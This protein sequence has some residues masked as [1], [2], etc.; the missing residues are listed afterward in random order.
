[1][2]STVFA[3]CLA[4]TTV[5]AQGTSPLP[6]QTQDLL[7]D[8][9]IRVTV[10][11][12]QVD[13]TVTDSKGRHVT[14]LKPRD[15][16]ILQDG[17]PQVI[18][19]FSSVTAP[20]SV[21]APVLS[22]LQQK[23]TPLLA[24]VKPQFGD[25][26]RT[27]ALVVDDL[28]LSFESTASIRQALK[29]FVDQQMQSGDLVAIIRT[30]AGIGALEQ[31]TTDKHLLYSA[32]DR[33]RFNPLGRVGISSSPQLESSVPN[34]RRV[35]ATDLDQGRQEMLTVG[36]L[37]AIRYVV[38][39]LRDLPGR[40]AVILFS[41]S[42]EILYGSGRDVRVMEDLQR[43]MDA[44]DRASVVMY[45]IDPRGLETYQLTAADDTRGLSAQQ[46]SQIPM[47]RSVQ[48]FNSTQ[49]M[50]MLVSQSGG[51][52]LHNT[53]DLNG[54]LRRA[55]DDTGTYYL[56]GYH[57]DPYTF[58]YKTGRPQFHRW[59]VR[60]KRPGLHL[61]SRSGFF[62][63]SDSE[64][65]LAQRNEPRQLTRALFSPFDSGSV[66]VRLTTLFST[67]S[68]LRPVLDSMLYID[69]HDVRFIDGPDGSRK[70][71]LNVIA[72][73][74]GEGGE[75]VA[76]NP[77]TFTLQINSDQYKR[78]LQDG[79]IYVQHQLLKKPGAYQLRIGLQDTA[80]GQLGSASQFIELPD[81]KK[82]RL[83]LSS[84]LF[85]EDAPGPTSLSEP[86]TATDDNGLARS[87]VLRAFHRGASLRF[88]YQVLNARTDTNHQPSLEVQSRLFRD[89]QLTYEGAWVR[90]NTT[91]QSD[92]RRLAAGGTMRLTS[93]M[94]AGDYVLE[95]IVRDQ[96][97]K[98]KY[99]VCSQSISFEVQP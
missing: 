64:Q 90:L 28:G 95:L 47:N 31:F 29:R 38:D 13:V 48:A 73:T 26:R 35:E 16:E 23:G 46:I 3:L 33:V 76:S 91:G 40:K 84:I 27:I 98:P 1:M 6:N 85:R 83:A 12:V 22:T 68:E 75:I 55:M 99:G 56:I 97:A 72:I 37:G 81:L 74:V 62:G 50:E 93:G 34:R 59:N 94:A 79:L 96:L 60:V 14:D 18:T 61:R 20:E 36:T 9:T 92:F 8:G 89:G 15:F 87:A 32:V 78:V 2:R 65:R 88:T 54:A 25:V 42:M 10:N 80:S 7:P 77:R 44:A 11:L 53:N 86:S 82:D 39:G 57:P 5:L 58:D 51:L 70:A 63:M 43:L 19:N 66:H 45:G 69:A 67:T 49:G 41:E 17:K 21:T 30:G 52:F 4:S 71:A 24:T